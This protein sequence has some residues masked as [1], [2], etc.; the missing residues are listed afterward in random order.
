MLPLRILVAD[1]HLL[2]RQGL[3]SL[4]QTRPDLVKV[5]GEASSGREA[6]AM[7]QDLHPDVAL[8]DIFMPEGDGLQAAKVI[9]ETVPKTAIVILTSSELDE[10]LYQA[11]RIGVAGYL[12]KTLDAH[13]LFDLLGG[14]EHDEAAMTRAMAAR[15]LRETSRRAGKTGLQ[16]EE[17]TE[18]EVEVLHLIVRGASNPEI[19]EALYIS[20]NTV[21]THIKNILTKL[22]LENRTQMAAYAVQNGLVS[23]AM[24][25]ADNFIHAFTPRFE[26][27]M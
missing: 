10:H 19:A 3:I 6:V 7:A 2:F 27:G 22:R 16:P 14:I 21:K 17:L 15:L 1:D 5:I 24:D 12:L 18:R 9:R 13:E 8:L 25:P 11:V 26:A 23:S 4:M 20:V